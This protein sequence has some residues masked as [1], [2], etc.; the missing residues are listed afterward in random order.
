MFYSKERRELRNLT[1]GL[2]HHSRLCWVKDY[3][4][5]AEI[6]LAFAHMEGVASSLW[7]LLREDSFELC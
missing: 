3:L 2:I 4:I 6:L 1:N 5:L 7:G